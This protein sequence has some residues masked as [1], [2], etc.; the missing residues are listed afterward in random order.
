MPKEEK[1]TPEE[2]K[3]I[4]QKIF[5]EHHFTDEEIN[6][7]A[8]QLAY[9][10][11]NLEQCKSKKES[12]VSEFDNKIKVSETQ[13]MSL[14]RNISSGSEYR[15]IVCEV[16]MNVPKVGIKTIT[17]PDTGDYWEEAMSDKER[18]ERLFDEGE[19]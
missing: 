9:E 16:R 10:N 3:P 12:V 13:I 19:E 15:D 1:E 11:N 18:Q 2:V 4:L 6:Q 17:R 5:L 7:L 8:K 14:S